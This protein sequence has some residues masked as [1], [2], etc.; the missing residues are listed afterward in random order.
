MKYVEQPTDKAIAI[1]FASKYSDTYIYLE[2][3]NLDKK[4]LFLKAPILLHI[5]FIRNKLEIFQ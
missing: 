5:F 3:K 2:K 4:N 1:T